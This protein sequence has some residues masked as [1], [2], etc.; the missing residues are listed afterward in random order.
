MQNAKKK[1]GARCSA[2]KYR[3]HSLKASTCF[4][5]TENKPPKFE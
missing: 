5:F 2:F 1:S 3:I 4:R